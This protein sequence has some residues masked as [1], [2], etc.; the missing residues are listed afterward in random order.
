MST[1]I[2]SNVVRYRKGMSVHPTKEGLTWTATEETKFWSG[3]PGHL[4]RE[5]YGNGPLFNLRI[6]IQNN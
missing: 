4:Y 6:A 5:D 2:D 3:S 1:R